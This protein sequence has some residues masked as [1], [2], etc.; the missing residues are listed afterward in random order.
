MHPMP[1]TCSALPDRLLMIFN[2]GLAVRL[3]R[4]RAY[5]SYTFLTEIPYIYA[6]IED[7]LERRLGKDAPYVTSFLRIG[8]WIGGDRDG[9]PF[10]T[11]DVMLRAVERQSSV[12]LDFYIDAVQKIGL[13]KISGW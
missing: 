2:C 11:H 10:V 6:K 5:Y 12:A 1:G 7:L 4:I 9:N 8:S 3:R 13:F